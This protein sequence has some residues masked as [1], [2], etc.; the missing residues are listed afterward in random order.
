VSE[1]FGLSIEESDPP[2]VKPLVSAQSFVLVASPPHQVGVDT[3]EEWIHLNTA[4][5]A[6]EGRELARW[7]W[8][9]VGLGAAG[10][11][12][13]SREVFLPR[14]RGL[15]C[16]PFP[17]P[18]RQSVHDLLG[19]TAYRRSSPDGMHDASIFDGSGQSDEAKSVP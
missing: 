18:A 7:R 10:G 11:L 12:V 8:P 17:A 6:M 19:H 1:Q 4:E 13:V 5:E 16:T 14:V 9:A 2:L 3:A 15:L